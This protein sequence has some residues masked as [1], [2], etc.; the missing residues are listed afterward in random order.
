MK[1]G[2]GAEIANIC[3]FIPRPERESNQQIQLA[4]TVVVVVVVVAA[5]CPQTTHN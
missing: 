3:L 5:V 1:A 4:F 2:T